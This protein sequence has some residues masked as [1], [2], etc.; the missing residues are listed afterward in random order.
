MLGFVPA[1]T[2]TNVLDWPELAP[3]Q[4]IVRRVAGSHNVV[5]IECIPVVN[6]PYKKV[7]LTFRKSGRRVVL[8]PATYGPTLAT[9][10][11]GT[12]LCV[13]IGLQDSSV[14]ELLWLEINPEQESIKQTSDRF[15]GHVSVR[16]ALPFEA[17]H[18]TTA[19][20]AKWHDLY[21][22]P[23]AGK[24][25]IFRSCTLESDRFRFSDWQTLGGVS[26]H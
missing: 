18:A 19:K 12:I 9:F 7:E 6:Q 26:G 13:G 22:G 21:D 17:M 23:A 24:T 5:E 11:D 8:V 16:T 3:R 2:F 20:F 4:P 10:T 14:T 25:R 15:R 1:A